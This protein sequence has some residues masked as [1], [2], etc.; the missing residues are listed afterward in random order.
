MVKK[1][2]QTSNKLPWLKKANIKIGERITGKIVRCQ[3]ISLPANQYSPAEERLVIEL[4]GFPY[5]WKPNFSS[6]NVM[7]DRFG[8]DEAQWRGQIVTICR[9]CDWPNDFFEDDK[10]A[11]EMPDGLYVSAVTDVPSNPATH[12]VDTTPKD[13]NWGDVDNV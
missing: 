1:Y 2:T 12:C 5:T 13:D 7:I 4:E 3:M 10:T 9:P 8:E 11:E 6:V